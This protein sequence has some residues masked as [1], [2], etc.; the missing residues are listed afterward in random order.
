M[1]PS[2]ESKLHKLQRACAVPDG[3]VTKLAFVDH[4]AHA[5]NNEIWSSVEAGDL[6]QMLSQLVLPKVLLTQ[7]E[8]LHH[9]RTITDNGG[10]FRRFHIVR[11]NDD[12]SQLDAV[13]GRPPRA[14]GT[15]GGFMAAYSAYLNGPM[16]GEQ[17]YFIPEGVALEAGAAC[18]HQE[19]HTF[20]QGKEVLGSAAVRYDDGATLVASRRFY[21]GNHKRTL[22]AL[23][24][25]A[26]IY[27]ILGDDLDSYRVPHVPLP[28][29]VFD[30]L[31]P[32]FLRGVEPVGPYDIAHAESFA[33]LLPPAYH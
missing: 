30:K 16:G 17:T 14:D 7:R 25:E 33:D 22:Q 21:P 10:V 27:D 13:A 31:N 24:V 2:S 3:A 12:P 29:S 11:V 8:L 32:I 19:I 1:H 9:W 20:A 6:E 23:A 4:T 28:E 26:N 5:A 18:L 15:F